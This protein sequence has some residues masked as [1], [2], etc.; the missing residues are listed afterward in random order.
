MKKRIVFCLFIFMAGFISIVFAGL[1]QTKAKAHVEIPV[2]T[3]K[4]EDVASPEAIVQAD[5]ESISGGV[6][7][8]RQWRR[9]H[10]LYDSHARFV[11]FTQDRKTGAIQKLSTGEQEFADDSNEMMVKE[12]FME[13]ELAHIVHR[14]GNVATVLSSYEG[15]LSSTG[16]VI[17]RGVN[18]Y[19]VYFE[20]ETVADS[21]RSLGRGDPR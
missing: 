19:Q 14:Y 21:L 10:T 2:I 12:G 11:S 9:D 4:G 8:P 16:K 3:V 20:R 1:A 15:K 5:Y 13:H 18:I 6:G 7:V 17:T